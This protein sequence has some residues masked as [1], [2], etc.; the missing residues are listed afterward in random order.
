MIGRAIF[1]CCI[2][3]TI[4]AQAANEGDVCIS[5]L[6]SLGAVYEREDPFTDPDDPA[7]GIDNPVVV[8]QIVEGVS[9]GNVLLECDTAVALATWVTD[10]V[11]PATAYLA[12]RGALTAISP[13]SSYQCR[14]RNNAPEGKLSEHAFGAGFDVMGFSFA[15]GP[16]LDVT[17]RDDENGLEAAFQSAVRKAGCL[18]FPTVLGPGTDAAH[19]DHFHF[20]TKER[21]GGYRICQ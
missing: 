14:R 5:A 16:S 21:N 9:V 13:G 6:A 20:D 12:D 17:V 1:L 4:D 8:D 7:C 11:Q 15:A 3:S 19:A 2:A 10:F 18:I